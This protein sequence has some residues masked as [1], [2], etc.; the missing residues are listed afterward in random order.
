MMN[1]VQSKEQVSYV[2]FNEAHPNFSAYCVIGGLD[3]EGENYSSLR[4]FDSK[5]LSRQYAEEL[6]NN[7]DYSRR[8]IISNDGTVWKMP[9]SKDTFQMVD[10]NV[11]VKTY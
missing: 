1:E 10:G 4:L 3:Y 9:G 11:E 7:Y 6:L 2:Q 5:E 8:F